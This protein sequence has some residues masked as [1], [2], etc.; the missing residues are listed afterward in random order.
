MTKNTN[1]PV[2]AADLEALHDFLTRAERDALGR[3]GDS[4]DAT[5]LMKAFADSETNLIARLR[6]LVTTD[7]DAR[8]FVRR[9]RTLVET[10]DSGEFPQRRGARLPPSGEMQW[11]IGAQLLR[12]AVTLWDA[13]VRDEAVTT[14]RVLGTVVED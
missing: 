1:P 2:D 8:A 12:A 4:F 11:T 7:D 14:Y 3:A 10:T 13:F 9:W 5:P 6:E